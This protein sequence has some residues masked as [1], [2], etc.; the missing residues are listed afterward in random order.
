MNTNANLNTVPANET[1]NADLAPSDIKSL[2]LHELEFIAG[3][4]ACDNMG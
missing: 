4:S 2:S 3:G 1:C